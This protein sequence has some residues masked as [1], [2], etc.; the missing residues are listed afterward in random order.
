MRTK[1]D[2]E[3]LI[4]DARA[5]LT[6]VEAELAHADRADDELGGAAGK[7]RA[8]IDAELGRR[9]EPRT[10]DEASERLWLHGQRRRA[11]VVESMAARE[12]AHR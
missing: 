3:K 9:G 10:D 11:G 6:E 2:R 12:K 4:Q 7:A 8:A 1:A 5:S